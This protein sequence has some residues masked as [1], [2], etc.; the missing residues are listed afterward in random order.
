MFLGPLG[1]LAG[2]VAIVVESYII[3]TMFTR[4]LIIEPALDALFDTI[5]TREGAGDVVVQGTT[6][7][8]RSTRLTAARERALS[9]VKSFSPGSLVQY[10]LTLPFNF[11]PVVGTV[12]Y[13]Y[14]NGSKLGRSGH[15][16]YF[17]LKGFSK[18][19]CD[20]FVNDRRGSYISFGMVALVLDL[21]P[22]VSVIFTFTNTAG[23]ALWAAK[24]E[25]ETRGGKPDNYK[26]AQSKAKKIA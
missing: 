13:L 3:I 5:L 25:N 26:E 10:V 11:I 17:V 19:E 20:A 14:L 2:I 4:S 23:S 21:V 9:S 22:L 7:S 1:T 16:R 12:V 15:K 6:K 24:M 18:D 8:G